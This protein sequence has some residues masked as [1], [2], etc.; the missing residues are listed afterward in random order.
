[1]ELKKIWRHSTGGWSY[2]YLSWKYGNKL[3]RHYK[4]QVAKLLSNWRPF[5]EN[6]ILIGPSA[7][8]ALDASFLQ[9][10]Q[11]ITVYEV[12]GLAKYLFS[13]KFQHSNIV[14][15]GECPIFKP[16]A[17]INKALWAIRSENPNAAI[18]FCN[19]LGQWPLIDPK[20]EEKLPILLKALNDLYGDSRWASFH[21]LFSGEL[22]RQQ[23]NFNHLP[24]LKIP[25]V[26]LQQIELLAQQLD[27]KLLSDHLT[28]Q[29]MSTSKAKTHF[30]WPLSPRQ[31]HIMEWIQ[32]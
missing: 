19:I 17:D 12:D 1:M 21:D 2:H 31:L 27:F 25:L 4:I 8:Y 11:K 13:K 9:R 22:K 32:S 28:F 14:W 15:K 24:E 10:F 30:F 5:T 7:G 18:L 6:L 3:W 23:L 29:R 26:E 20:S 16:Q